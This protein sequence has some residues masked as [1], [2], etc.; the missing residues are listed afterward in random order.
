MAIYSDNTLMSMNKKELIDIIRM[1]EYNL[2]NAN[3][4]ISV[5]YN[6]YKKLLKKERNKAIDDV[7]EALDEWRGNQKYLLPENIFELL[8]QLK[9]V[10]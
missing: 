9:E 10:E 2:K 1:L 6:N 5:Q 4:T 7:I 3:D 8:E